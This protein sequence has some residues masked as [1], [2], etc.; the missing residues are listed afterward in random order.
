MTVLVLAAASFL[1][2]GFA[3]GFANRRRGMW[4]WAA[5]G[6]LSLLSL[7]ISSWCWFGFFGVRI[8]AAVDSFRIARGQPPQWRSNGALGVVAFG[9]A[10]AGSLV[11]RFAV[12]EAFRIPAS[13]GY[14]TLEIGDHVFV[15][16][17]S[18]RWRSPRRG[19]IIVFDQPCQPAVQY[20]KRVIAV[21]DDTVEVR[22]NVVYVNGT[23]VTE[24]LVDASCTYRDMEPSA[25]ESVY[26]RECS[27]YRETLDGHTFEVFHDRARVRRAQAHPPER[28]DHR[29][30]P[31]GLTL[32][33]CTNQFGMGA[34][35]QGTQPQL[36]G[37]IIV[38][39]ADVPPETSCQPHRHYKVP[40]GHLFVMGDNRANSNDSR[41]W[42]SVPVENVVGRVVSIWYPLGRIGDVR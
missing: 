29:D 20:I 35:P 30:F 7:G 4:L 6:V 31:S 2:P 38:A 18:K 41:V 23:A 13:S 33:S 40:A 24:E 25:A 3:H 34:A 10:F 11:A 26:E 39:R 16:K 21:G 36:P 14:P 19:E 32:P 27:R 37:A 15:E 42:G 8:G 12:L 22:C 9:L 5:L 1:V 28:V 17:L